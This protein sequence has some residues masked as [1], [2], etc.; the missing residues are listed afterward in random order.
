MWLHRDQWLKKKIFSGCF[1]MQ[2]VFFFADFLWI[3]C[4]CQPQIWCSGIL[5]IYFTETY[6]CKWSTHQKVKTMKQ[7]VLNKCVCWE[8]LL[9]LFGWSRKLLLHTPKYAH[10]H[11]HI[12]GAQ[13]LPKT[14]PACHSAGILMEHLLDHIPTICHDDLRR[15]ATV[16]CTKNIKRVHVCSR[17]RLSVHLSSATI[18]WK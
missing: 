3:K 5:W 9:V 4:F 18:C 16:N 12:H 11:S 7:P 2:R 17:V 1:F 6:F 10:T 14:V 15:I 13:F 8:S